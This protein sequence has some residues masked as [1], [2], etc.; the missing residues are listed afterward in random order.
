M[1]K[2]SCGDIVLSRRNL[3]S[4]LH[5]L[6][7]PGSARML[8]APDEAFCVFVEDDDVHYNGRVPGK[9]HPETEAFIKSWPEKN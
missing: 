7:M 8:V 6:D 4:L 1:R 2:S 9:M 3:L 5:K